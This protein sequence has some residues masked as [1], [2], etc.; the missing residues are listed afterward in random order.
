MTYWFKMEWLILGES[1]MGKYTF[2]HLIAGLMKS[3]T[4]NVEIWKSG[5][6]MLV[7]KKL[8]VF[9]ESNVGITK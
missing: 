7:G 2:L 5:I 4:G 9:S 1:G 3:K 6:T 8:D